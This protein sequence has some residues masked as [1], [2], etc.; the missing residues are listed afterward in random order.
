MSVNKAIL[1]GN[2]GKEPQTKTFQDGGTSVSF[3]LATT[4]RGYTLKNGQEVSD[5]T[6]WHNVVIRGKLG[7]VASKYVN[8]G[9]KLY[10]EGEI[11]SRQYEK[12]GVKHTIVEIFAD[13]MEMLS[14]KNSN[15]TEPSEPIAPAGASDDLP[16]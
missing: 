5:R 2:V 14:P 7:E 6:E 13:K 12:D 16:F 11:R 4:V 9:D 10:I 1:L 15:T 8:K 3:S